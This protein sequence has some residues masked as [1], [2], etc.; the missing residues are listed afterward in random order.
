MTGIFDSGAGGLAA[1]REL[2][3][4]NQDLDILFLADSQNAPYGTKTEDEILA[5]TEKNITRLRAAG[6]ERVLIACC[7]AST[8]YARLGTDLQ[9][10][11]VPIIAP[12]AELAVS[13][14][15]TRKIAVIATRRTVKCEAFAKS[16]KAK[17]SATRVT[18]IEAQ[19]L[20]R[21]AEHIC[22]GRLMTDAEEAYFKEL[23]ARIKAT[24]ADTLVLGCTHFSHLENKF[25]E[26]IKNIKTVDA[27][28][29][30]A[31]LIAEASQCGMGATVF[32]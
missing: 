16:I 2:R 27:A 21:I 1:L 8:V 23:L 26:N 6:A 10:I 7:T 29:T 22:A 12:T 4:I 14:T 17:D 20:V 5:L 3:R 11:S 30:G 28:K 31:R 32:L 19:P 24:D 18:E 13:L 15:K 25:K 9:K